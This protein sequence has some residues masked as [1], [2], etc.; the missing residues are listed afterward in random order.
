MNAR[1]TRS[2]A[3]GRAVTAGVAAG[4]LAALA[5]PLWPGAAAAAEAPG[6]TSTLSVGVGELTPDNQRFG[7]YTGLDASGSYLLLDVDLNHLNTATG[8]WLQ[9]SGRNL[10]LDSRELRLRGEHQGDWGYTLEFRDIPR[11]FPYAIDSAL[12]GVGTASLTTN[13]VAPGGG[14][15]L[16]LGTDRKV[17]QAGMEKVLPKGFDIKVTFR[18]EQKDGTRAFGRTGIDFLAEPIDYTTRQWETAL[19]YTGTRLQVSGGYYGTA[20]QNANRGLVVDGVTDGNNNTYSPIGLPPDNVSHQIYVNGGY[21]L[22]RATRADFQLAYGRITQNDA[23]IPTVTLAPGVGTDLNGEIRTI[24]TELGLTSRPTSK[25][26]LSANARRESRDDRTPVLV[27]YSGASASSR[28]NGENE[29]RDFITTAGKLEAVYRLPAQFRVTGGVNLEHIHRNISA[30]RS[31]SMRANTTET[32]YRM[33]LGRTMSGDL[34]GRLAYIH[35]VRGGSE[36]PPNV[37]NGG[38]PGS[39]NIAPIHYSDRHRDQVRATLAATPSDRVSLQLVG[40]AAWDRYES[41]TDQ[42][43]GPRNGVEGH[44]S[45]DATVQ[46]AKDWNVTAFVSRDHT[47]QRQN[48]CDG[49]SSS[50]APCAAV[51]YWKAELNNWGYAGG[52]SVRGKAGRKVAL[53]ADVQTSYDKGRYDQAGSPVTQNIPSLYY[54][55]LTVSGFGDLALTSDSGV[56]LSATYNQQR[57]NDWSWVTWSYADGTTVYQDPKEDVVFVG[58][59]YHRTWL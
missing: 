47:S 27:Y 57:T 29:P 36:F 56:S 31:A 34:D 49:I 54:R 13:V 22:A 33:E 32:A 46:V 6:P 24:L 11:K 26:S 19:S 59:R 4:L 58:V 37:L 52:L 44:I 5:A 28:T 17:V 3:A 38:G 2:R 1:S 21:N 35:S 45:A 15:P 55:P 14:D 43:L 41:R 48:S 40:D 42:H 18:N 23:F 7:Q 16:R 25:L 8:T 20:F 9:L 39:D 12:Q 50:G 30:V 53:G 51:D 10:G